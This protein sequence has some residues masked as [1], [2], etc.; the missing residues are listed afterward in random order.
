MGFLL[1]NAWTHNT[2]KGYVG[3]MYRNATDILP[4]NLIEQ[5]QKYVHGQEIYIPKRTQTRLGWG[6]GNGTRLQLDR[7][8]RAIVFRYMQGESIESLM[9]EYHLSYDSI[10]KIVRR[11]K[12]ELFR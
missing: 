2:R 6:E 10:R 12:K 4:R 3:L 7:R 8:N 11:G 5:I 9:D 1:A